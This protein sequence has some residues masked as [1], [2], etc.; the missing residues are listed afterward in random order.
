MNRGLT[1]DLNLAFPNIN[2]EALKL[3]AKLDSQKVLLSD[4][5]KANW[6]SGFTTGEGSFQ[7]SILKSQTTKIG[8]QILLRFC[9]GQHRRDENLLIS[10]IDYLDC[11]TVHKKTNSKYNTDFF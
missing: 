9:I 5:A 3:E 7:V 4:S 2:S 11:G 6:L 8:Y 10:L 1:P